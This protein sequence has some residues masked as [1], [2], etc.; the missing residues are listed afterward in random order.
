MNIKP[1]CCALQVA[2]DITLYHA[3][4]PLDLGPLPSFFYFALSGQDSLCTDPYNQIVQF[5]HGQMIRVFSMTLPAHESNLPASS[6]IK[7]WA[8]DYLA[9]RDPIEDFLQKF[10]IAT[11]FAIK[12]HFVNPL[13]LAIGGLSRGGFIALHAAARDPRFRFIL[14]LAPITELDKIHEFASMQDH[15]AIRALNVNLLKQN[16]WN[17]TIRFHIGNHDSLVDTKACFHFAMNLVEEAAH[18]NLR[19]PQIEFF[20][21]PSIGHKG[22]GT[23]LDVFR[24][25]SDWICS[26]LLHS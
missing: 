22:H 17:R 10:F 9:S 12:N 16:L 3:G 19:S 11:E 4:P 23:P 21:H 5:L 14:P 24:K 8:E 15:P 25:G 20:T 13:K 1:P 18:H 6:A 2:P 7:T 26:C